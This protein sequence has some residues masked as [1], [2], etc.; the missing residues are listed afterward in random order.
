M[1]RKFFYLQSHDGRMTQRLSADELMSFGLSKSTAYRAIKNGVLASHRV[2]QLQFL[3]FG[4]IPGWDGWKIYPG[5]IVSPAGQEF[6]PVDLENFAHMRCVL[7]E[8]D[9]KD[10]PLK[11]K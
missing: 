7:S 2:R 9:I 6:K 11:N 8:Y 4:N 5:K 10:L 1:H 3:I